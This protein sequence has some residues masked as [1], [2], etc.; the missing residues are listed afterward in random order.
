M[1]SIF[2]LFICFSGIT[3]A[4]AQTHTITLGKGDDCKGYNICKLSSFDKGQELGAQ[5]IPIYISVPKEHKLL[6]AFPK[7]KVNDQTFLKYFS[8]GSFVL[9][10]DYALPEDI[11]KLYGDTHLKTGKYKV[12]VAP[13]AYEVL[14]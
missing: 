14:F 9:D 10:G 13:D 7:S 1:K 6:F 11:A 8:T 4:S 12:V 2:L 5:D 3:I